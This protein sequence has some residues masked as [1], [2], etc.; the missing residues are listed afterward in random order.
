M[1]RSALAAVLVACIAGSGV[2]LADAAAFQNLSA[3]SQL[4]VN[5]VTGDKP[6]DTAICAQGPDGLREAVTS[7][8][9]DLYFAGNLKG[10][11]REAGTAAGEYLKAV[12]KH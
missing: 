11:P 3:D 5:K 9:K 2:A 8:T 10:D 6:S 1:N 12:C 4:I 7:A